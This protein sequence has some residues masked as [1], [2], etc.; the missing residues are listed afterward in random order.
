MKVIG[1]LSYI[2]LNVADRPASSHL[3][4]GSCQPQNT[5]RLHFPGQSQGRSQIRS[6][7]TICR[8]ETREESG[9]A[10]A[11]GRAGQGTPTNVFFVGEFLSGK[12]NSVD[13]NGQK[14]FL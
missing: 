8:S 1:N 10:A 2:K 12:R 13:L 9:A 5:P 6:E 4:S 7:G 3:M 14:T 11:Q